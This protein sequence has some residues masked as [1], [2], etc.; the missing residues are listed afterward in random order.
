[1]TDRERAHKE[2]NKE[3]AIIKFNGGKGAI[4]CSTCGVIIKT[5]G[6]LSK[7]ELQLMNQGELPA[8][9]CNEHK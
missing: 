6:T 3:T 4:L 1:M 5:F 7:E 8:Q 2:R 9:Y